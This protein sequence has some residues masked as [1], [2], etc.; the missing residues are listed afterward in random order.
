MMERMLQALMPVAPAA[1]Q[2]QREPVNKRVSDALMDTGRQ[3]V[4][5]PKPEVEIDA[6]LTVSGEEVLRGKD[7][8]Q[9]SAEEI[10]AARR[11]VSELVMP[12]D[13]VR[14]RRLEPARRARAI[15]M[16]ASLRASLRSGGAMIDL[17]R[18]RAKE[19]ISPV[20]ALCDISGSMS[21]YTQIFLHF[22]HAL[23]EQRT[24]HSF[25][26]GTR[27][28]NVTRAL[29]N[30]D[31]ED[32][33]KRAGASVQDWSGGTRI[34]AC[35]EEFNRLWSRRVLG[36]GAVVLLITDGL[37]RDVHDDALVRAMERLHLSSRRLVW[38]NPLLRF[39]GFEARATGIRQMLP[40]VDEFRPVHNIEALESL[41]RAL[42]GRGARGGDTRKWLRQIA[43][44]AA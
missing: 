25:V 34:A 43:D 30:K 44:M 1:A 7:F 19:R 22:L 40:H 10:M 20:V 31:P 5:R 3:E 32:A 24:V 17:R 15:D 16:R 12:F 36:Q 18:A 33:L 2:Q 6:S 29:R 42:D 11:A 8:A 37:E 39:D 4:E 23:S 21:E 14:T 26:F 9:M 35:I 41:T 38:L 28:T 27:L 13:T